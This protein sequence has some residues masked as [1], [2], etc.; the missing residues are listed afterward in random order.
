MSLVPGM[1]DWPVCVF[2]M[3]E[4][5]PA[6][7]RPGAASATNTISAAS[8]VR[9]RRRRF[10]LS[11]PPPPWLPNVALKGCFRRFLPPF[12]A[13]VK[14]P[15]DDRKGPAFAGPS[16]S[17]HRLLF[18]LSL[19]PADDQL[20]REAAAPDRAR[21]RA[22]ADHAPAQRA[23]GANAADAADRAVGPADPRPRDAEPEPDHARHA[24]AGRRWRRRWRRWRR[25]WVAVAAA[26]VAVAV[27][28]VAVAVGAEV[29][30]AVAAEVAVAA[31]RWS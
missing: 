4:S 14:P 25:R 27:A 13:E 7:A 10:R 2:V 12:P 29:A 6:K 21:P 31:G 16:S 24:A 11:I 19:P 30:E 20:D 18:W 1:I 23:P 8:A 26:A 15:T 5:S 3:Y 22:L 17:S 28:E 9:Q